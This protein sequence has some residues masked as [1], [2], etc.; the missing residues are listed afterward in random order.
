MALAAERS[1]EK[2][3]SLFI[4]RR[5]DSGITVFDISY[6]DITIFEWKS[7]N[8]APGVARARNGKFLGWRGKTAS[9]S[10]SR[11]SC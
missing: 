9:P 10:R 6:A 7:Q 2:H 4:A 3:S 8:T 1:R 5:M 11:M